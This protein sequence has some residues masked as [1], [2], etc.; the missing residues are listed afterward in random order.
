MTKRLPLLLISAARSNEF[1]NQNQKLTYTISPGID[2]LMAAV[3]GEDGNDTEVKVDITSGGVNA[4]LDGKDG[5]HA[6]QVKAGKKYTVS[7][8]NKGGKTFIGL[9]LLWVGDT[10]NVKYPVSAITKVA[11]LMADAIGQ[12]E[13]QGFAIPVGRDSFQGA[14]LNTYPEHKSLSRPMF[15]GKNW[16]TIAASDAG[17]KDISMRITDSNKE[18]YM[19]S[20]DSPKLSKLAVERMRFRVERS[21]F[22]ARQKRRFL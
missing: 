12:M 7:V 2:G 6:F 3:Y 15:N 21:L 22:P 1:F 13:A 14:V 19:T 10:S 9:A 18:A 20:S 16:T 8:T 5:I 11:N 4:M 17:A